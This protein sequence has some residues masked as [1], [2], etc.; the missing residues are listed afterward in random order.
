LLKAKNGQLM[1]DRFLFQRFTILGQKIE[2]AE[3]RAEG[4]EAENK[5][6]APLFSR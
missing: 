4:A 1:K 6:V 3:T 5:K 2:A